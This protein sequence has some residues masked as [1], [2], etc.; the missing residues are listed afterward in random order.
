MVAET[1]RIGGSEEGERKEGNVRRKVRKNQSKYLKNQGI[2]DYNH[3]AAA[4]LIIC[5][6]EIPHIF[7]KQFY[8]RVVFGCNKLHCL[9]LPCSQTL[10]YSIKRWCLKTVATTVN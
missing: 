7:L 1:Q 10:E 8:K 3:D 9:S 4:H 5:K 6:G 2:P